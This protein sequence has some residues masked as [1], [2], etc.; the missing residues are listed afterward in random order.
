MI[1]RKKLD[2]GWNDLFYGIGSCF[3][4]NST[5]VENSKEIDQTW[6]HD[7][8]SLVCLS[9]RSGFDA[10]LKALSF[11]RGSEVVCSAITISDMV[12]ILK[13]HGLVPVPIDMDMDT[14][15]IDISQIESS[16]T[17][18]T[19][20]ILVAHLFGSLMPMEPIIALARRHKIIVF[21]DCAQAFSGFDYNGHPRSDV[22]M[23]SFG[24]I[25]TSTALGGGLLLYRDKVLRNAVESVQLGYPVQSVKEYFFRLIKY[26]FLKA[27]INPIC[28]EIMFRLCPI[29]GTTHDKIIGGSVR[30]F[31]GPDFFS[32][33]RRQPC[34]ALAKLLTKRIRHF[35]STV[36]EKRVRNAHTFISLVPGI[37]RPGNAAFRHTH[38]VFPVEVEQPDRFLAHLWQHGIDAT[39]GA[40]NLSAVDVPA[41]SSFQKPVDAAAR[42]EKM[43]YIP[44]FEG[45]KRQTVRKIAKTVYHFANAHNSQLSIYLVQHGK[46]A[47][48]SAPKYARMIP[49]REFAQFLED[50]NHTGINSNVAPPVTL[51]AAAANMNVLFCSSLFRAV[52]SF[53]TLAPD[54]QVL[55]DPVFNE[56]AFPSGFNTAVFFPPIIWM[57]IS[58]TLWRIGFSQE[59]ESYKDTLKRA[60]NAAKILHEAALQHQ[61]VMLLGHGLMNVLIRKELCSSGWK[62]SGRPSFSFWGFHRL[63]W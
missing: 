39:Q 16:L 43:V 59:V 13:A 1:P 7:K 60:K 28:F 3:F 49:G 45:V 36:I 46:P 15:S 11:P 23:F 44:V 54:R 26:T 2:I 53:R 63:S 31:A 27:I 29:C 58:R 37:R 18:R 10:T 20:G 14:L 40:S 5:S 24:P 47:V 17:K 35:K 48:W 56:A 38:W 30:G 19:K 42:I 25:K 51:V 21:E 41:N 34:G 52:Q 57:I 12:K 50:Y 6:T 62:F 33:I 55:T 9:V 32:R 61:K 8:S 22:T 4:Q